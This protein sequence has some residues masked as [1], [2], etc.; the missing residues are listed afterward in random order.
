M[1]RQLAVAA[2]QQAAAD[3]RAQAKALADALIAITEIHQEGFPTATRP[4][5][6]APE[7]VDQSAIRTAHRKA[8]K[9]STSVFARTAR[10][11]ALAQ[12]EL[13][14]NAEIAA[15]AARRGAAR[16]AYQSDLDAWW[17]KVLACDPD[18][19]LG[20]LAT[21]FEDNEA[22]AA[23]V[24]V[25]GTEVSLVVVVPSETAIP[26]RKPTTTQ[27]GNLS[28]KKLTKTEVADLYKM[29]VCGHVLVTLREAFAVVPS[30]TSARIIAVRASRRDANAK[31]TAEVLMAGRCERSALDVRWT[32][33]GSARIFND[34]L[35]ERI[36]LQEGAISALQPVP[37]HDEPALR[38]VVEAIDIEEL[39]D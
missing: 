9:K 37:V 34:C 3:K 22:A 26:D 38:A 27:A 17:A 10:K 4:V 19:V 39:A 21:A 15:E 18:T 36:A 11:A 8:A 6:P 14:A 20:T 32:D 23:A 7:P 12:G 31:R 30:L 16:A 25:D 5:A 2:R 13:D 28:L 24:G 1:N 29:L 35:T 33:A